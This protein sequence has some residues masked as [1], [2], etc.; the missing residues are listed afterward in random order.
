LLDN[1]FDFLFHANE[2]VTKMLTLAD[3]SASVTGLVVLSSALL[4]IIQYL[5]IRSNNRFDKMKAKINSEPL[6]S[7]VDSASEGL[8]KTSNKA[9]KIRDDLQTLSLPNPTYLIVLLLV[10]LPL[11]AFMHFGLYNCTTPKMWLPITFQ[12]VSFI[13]FLL[14]VLMLVWIAQIK[15]HTQSLKKQCEEYNKTFLTLKTM[16]EIIN[17]NIDITKEQ[18]KKKNRK[19]D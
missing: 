9:K 17:E 3:M 1:I 8:I 5:D 2:A 16:C 12:V 7:L 14:A 11:Y 6:P 19:A 15:Y 10:L 18:K 13:V 4:A